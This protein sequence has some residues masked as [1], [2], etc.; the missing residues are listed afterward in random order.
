LLPLIES[1]ITWG[2]IGLLIGAIAAV[3]P[4]PALRYLFG[5]TWVIFVCALIRHNLFTRFPPILQ[6]VGNGVLSVMI[7][8]GLIGLFRV[9]PKPK[10]FPTATEIAAAQHFPTAAEIAQEASRTPPHQGHLP[11]GAPPEVK[12]IFKDSPLFTET[13]KQNITKV[14]DEAY[15]YLV[16]LGFP[17]EKEVPPLGVSPLNNQGMSGI[18]PGAVYERNIYFPHNSLDDSS[19]I[20]RVYLSYAFG[21]LF[22]SFGG[23]DLPDIGTRST[24]STLY[25][26][27]YASS[28]GEKN[29]D[30]NEWRGHRWMEA[31]WEIRHVQGRDATDQYMYYAYRTWDD[32]SIRA[33]GEFENVFPARFMAGVWIKD[34]FGKSVTV[35]GPILEKYNLAQ[36]NAK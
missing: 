6:V 7:A 29:L 19:S 30:T 3:A 21:L 2:G 13:R 11:K 15:K 12:I 16:N 25:T 27:Y 28:I 1:P 32:D 18:F 36:P 4:V 17:L 14:I 9:L 10:E 20:R 33:P 23:G 22:R 35:V 31:L 8:G 5:L 34:N 24:L 26:V